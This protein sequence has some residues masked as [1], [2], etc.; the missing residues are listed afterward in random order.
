ML[1][2]NRIYSLGQRSKNKMHFVYF[3]KSLKNSK[4]YV[5]KTEKEPSKRIMEHNKGAN[6]WTKSNGPF[7]VIYFEKYE[8]SKDA[9]MR[10]DFYKHGFGRKIKKL[11]VDALDS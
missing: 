1:A 6:S 4:V 3:A 7:K 10:E 8:C 11:I 5:G 9:A 2:T